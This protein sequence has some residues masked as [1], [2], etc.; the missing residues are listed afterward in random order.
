V[1]WS[2]AVTCPSSSSTT[3]F[4]F[5]FLVHHPRWK[6]VGTCGGQTFSWNFY[7]HPLTK[8]EV[9][10]KKKKNGKRIRKR[11]LV[12]DSSKNKGTTPL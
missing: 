12:G 11:R 8:I 1:H 2:E 7:L 4:F 6:R 3:T 9:F 5:F 10:T